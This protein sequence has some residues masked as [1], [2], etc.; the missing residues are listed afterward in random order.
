MN[1]LDR[2]S[3]IDFDLDQNQL[4]RSSIQNRA[5]PIAALNGMFAA[6]SARISRQPEAESP[7]EIRMA[8]HA[9][10]APDASVAPHANNKEDDDDFKKQSSSKGGKP[11][12]M[13]NP[14]GDHSGAAARREKKTPGN[15]DVVRVRT[16]YE[17]ATGNQWSNSDTETYEKHGLGQMPA[18]KIVS[19]LEAVLQRIPTKINSFRYF[20][21]EI[22][23]VPERRNRAW[24]KNQLEKIV[25]KIRDSSVGRAGYSGIDFLQDVKCA[26]AWEGIVFNDDIYNKLVG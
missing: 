5:K 21:K 8:P 24:Q 9:T 11:L 3:F 14:N 2:E 7:V 23:A 19:V 10:V 20:I 17:K 15:P 18:D 13:V 1:I 26:C 12:S 16:A 6:P 4:E 22:L 25:R